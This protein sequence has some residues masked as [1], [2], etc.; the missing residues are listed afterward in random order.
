MNASALTAS[1]LSRYQRA[2]DFFIQLRDEGGEATLN[3]WMAW[4]EEDPQNLQVFEEIRAVWD[5]TGAPPAMTRQAP[6]PRRFA[7]LLPIAAAVL[8]AV[9]AAAFFALRN[10]TPVS[11]SKLSTPL[12]MHSAS[13]LDDGSKLSLGGLSTVSTRFSDDERLVVIESGEAFFDVAPDVKRPFV[14]QV[15]PVAI[16]AIGTAFNVRRGPDH[17][18]VAVTEGRVGIGTGA[19]EPV[20]VDANQKISYSMFERRF[21]IAPV[22]PDAA[23]SWQKG[24]FKYVGEPLSEVVADLNRYASHR[25][26]IADETLAS[27]RYTGTIFGSRIDEWLE[28]LQTAFPVELH[29]NG[30]TLTLSRASAAAAP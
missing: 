18:V 7:S 10:P 28:A 24:V 30:A 5:A 17:I 11:S 25:I 19:G 20:I 9:G 21:S 29:E 12:A 13:V 15:G 6:Q 14:V 27:E 22:N 1:E 23:T 3:E 26:V 4:C 16:T 8:L 2:A